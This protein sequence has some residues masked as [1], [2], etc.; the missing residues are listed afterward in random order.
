MKH[1]LPRNPTKPPLLANTSVAI[2]LFLL[3]CMLLVSILFKR[4]FQYFD[5]TRPRATIVG[6]ERLPRP[7]GTWD[8]SHGSQEVELAEVVRDLMGQLTAKTILLKQLVSESQH[9]IERMEEL[10]DRM[11]R[12]SAEK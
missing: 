3:G 10:L 6:L 11:E 7:Q 9:Q 4:S 5:K 1:D 12:A 8:G 2:F